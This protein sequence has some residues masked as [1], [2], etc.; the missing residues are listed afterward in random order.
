MPFTIVRQDSIKMTV[1]AIVNRKYDI[2]QINEVLFV[3]DQS[4]LGA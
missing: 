2:F 4:L 3:Y 1:D